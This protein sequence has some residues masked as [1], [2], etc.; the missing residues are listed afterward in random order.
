M[1][2]TFGTLLLRGTLLYPL[3]PFLSA[4]PNP[5]RKKGG[6][7][8]LATLIRVAA[9]A[10]VLFSTASFLQHLHRVPVFCLL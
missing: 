5:N 8:E 1:T 6:A 7:T 3:L 2:V 10:G 4:H 9:V